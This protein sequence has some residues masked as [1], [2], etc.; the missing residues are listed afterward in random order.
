MWTWSMKP[1]F[2]SL[3]LKV[4]NVDSVTILTKKFLY[5]L[6]CSICLVYPSVQKDWI[7][8]YIKIGVKNIKWMKVILDC[9]EQKNKGVFKMCI[10]KK[11]L[12]QPT[13]PDAHLSLWNPLNA[14]R[15]TS[16]SCCAFVMKGCTVLFGEPRDAFTSF[17][18][19]KRALCVRVFKVLYFYLNP[20]IALPS[21]WR[22]WRIFLKR[23]Y[24]IKANCGR[25]ILTCRTAR[26]FPECNHSLFSLLQFN[27]VYFVQSKIQ[28]LPPI[29]KHTTSLTFD[30]TSD[31]K[32]LSQGKK[33]R[34]EGDPSPRLDRIHRCHVTR[35]KH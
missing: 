5:L 28:N 2:P 15:Q 25:G 6:P 13:P 4:S 29:C 8:I 7:R 9:W 33:R 27:P 16:T 34:T 30:L 32:K 1:T 24:K 18:S 10:L 12:F 21:G 22:F 35:R 14:T 19:S 23:Y 31:Q 17:P 26:P 20:S 3:P 11:S